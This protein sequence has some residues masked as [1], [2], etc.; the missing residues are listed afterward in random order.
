MPFLNEILSLNKGRASALP[1]AYYSTN[2]TFD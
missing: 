1:F 2:E